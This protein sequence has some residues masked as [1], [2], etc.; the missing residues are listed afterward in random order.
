MNISSSQRENM[1]AQLNGTHSTKRESLGQTDKRVI[2]KLSERN[3][4]MNGHLRKGVKKQPA[5]YLPES[6]KRSEVI[7]AR[8]A[9][10]GKQGS[11][12][13]VQAWMGIKE[14]RSHMR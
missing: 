3:N 6:V 12:Q 4:T 11:G 14:A 13:Y 5:R 10:R 1:N 9:R 8:A 7:D 2:F